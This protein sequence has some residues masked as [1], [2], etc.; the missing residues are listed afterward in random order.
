MF[1]FNDDGNF[2]ENECLRS[3]FQFFVG[4]V[5]IKAQ[6]VGI[7]DQTGERII[8]SHDEER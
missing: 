3:K 5:R 1:H 4:S 6:A 8:Y 2:I 7:D